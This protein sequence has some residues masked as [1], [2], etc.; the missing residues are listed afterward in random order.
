MKRRAALER[1][2]PY[3][4]GERRPGAVKLSSNENP[5]GCSPAAARAAIA[6]MEEAHI[7]PDGAARDLKA[8]LAEET[9]MKPEEIILG[10]G[11]DEVLTFIAAAYINPGDRTLVGEHTFSQY[12]F[13]TN[14]MDGIV[15]TVPMPDLR[16]DPDR[17][18]ER[19]S[20]NVRALFL[21]SPNNPTGLAISG[22]ELEH[23]LRKVPRETLV[24]MDHAYIDYQD[25]P[26]ACDAR[27]YIREYPNLVVLRTFSK[28]YGLA[29]LRIGFGLAVPERIAEMERVRSPF[30]VSTIA[31]HAAMAAL[32]D[33]PFVTSTLED[34]RTGKARM[35]AL[36]QEL[37]LPHIP[38][39]ANFL[40][41]AVPTDAREFAREIANKGI[42]VRPLNSFGLPQHIR[43][44]IG[45]PDQI[46]LLEAAMRKR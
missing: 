39:Q 7:Y 11:S 40:T 32:K 15:E 22:N 26:A 17:F 10:N 4:A 19:I 31:Q 27:Q 20:E 13:A 9:G 5:R 44:T 45:T 36:F 14:L 23:L 37:G 35:I 2:T 25:D 33:E 8:L 24:V 28:I 46:E 1:M 6:A 43:I 30:N 42:T 34:N 29:A 21:C 3:H 18:L 41:I 38:S 16:M 12:R